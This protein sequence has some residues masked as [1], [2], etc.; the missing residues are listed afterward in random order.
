[1]IAVGNPRRLPIYKKQSA[2]GAQHIKNLEEG[3][4]NREARHDN[5]N[6]AHELDENV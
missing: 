4:G 5:G 3:V 1:M 6:H 2:A